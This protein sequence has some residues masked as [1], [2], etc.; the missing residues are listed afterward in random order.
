VP[1]DLLKL[2]V[3]VSL[4]EF[5]SMGSDKTKPSAVSKNGRRFRIR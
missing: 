4:L 5:E 1:L 2:R 3:I